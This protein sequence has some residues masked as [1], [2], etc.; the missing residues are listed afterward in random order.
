MIANVITEL[1]YL[2]THQ[3]TS[4]SFYLT[5]LAVCVFKAVLVVALALF[6]LKRMVIGKKPTSYN[7]VYDNEMK[8]KLHNEFRNHGILLYISI[9]FTYYTGVY[10]LIDAKNFA[11]EIGIGFGVDILFTLGL[12]F[13][14]GMNNVGVQSG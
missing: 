2:T 4:I 5:Y 8:N 7:N 11:K 13:I 9:C 6:K 1:A 3:F 10:R 12:L 14:Q